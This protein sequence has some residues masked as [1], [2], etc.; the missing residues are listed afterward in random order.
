MNSLIR[1]AVRQLSTT[2]TKKSGEVPQGKVE[3]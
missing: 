3:I 2:V 1:V